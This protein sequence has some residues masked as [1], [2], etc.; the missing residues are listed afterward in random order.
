MMWKPKWKTNRRKPYTTIGIKRMKCIRCAAPAVFQWSICSDNN[1]YRP[2]CTACDVGLNRM[3]LR[4]MRHPDAKA[5]GD[6][7]E[8]SKVGAKP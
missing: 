4:W 1:R 3:V 7:Y 2:L 6:A 5:A 8:A